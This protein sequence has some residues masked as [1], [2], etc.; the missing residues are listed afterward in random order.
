MHQLDAWQPQHI[1]DLMRVDEHG[2]RAMRDDGAGELGHRHHAA[3]DMHM[4]VAQTRHEI[5]A[6][7]LDDLRLGAYGMGRIGTHI[8]EAF[9]DD[10]DIGIWNDLA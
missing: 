10:R 7:G 3:F 1:G 8:S 9:G 5:S 6:I 4:P 2:G